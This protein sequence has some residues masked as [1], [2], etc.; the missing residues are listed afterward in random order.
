MILSLIWKAVILVNRIDELI[1]EKCPDGVEYKKLGTLCEKIKN[2]VWDEETKYYIDLSAVSIELHTILEN[3]VVQITKDSAPS[4]AKQVVKG[5]DILFGG[6]RPMQGR[7]CVVP[8]RYEGYIASTGFNIVRIKDKSVLNRY[9][10]HCMNSRNFY[11][12]VETVQHGASYPA[13][14]DSEMK[15]YEIPIP[16]IEIQQEIV[17]ILDKFTELEAGLQ[18]ELDARKK[19]YEYYRNRLFNFNSEIERKSVKIVCDY[20]SNFAAAGSFADVSKNVPYLSEPNYAQLIRTVDIKCNYT[21]KSP[22][23][24]SEHSFNYLWRVNLNEPS[25]VL[26]SVGNCGEV[27]Y[28]EPSDLPYERNVLAKNALLVRS[29]IVNMKFLK[30]YFETV[31][32]QKQLKKITSLLGQTKFNK[33]DF[34]KL[35]IPVPTKNEQERIVQI[36]ESFDKICNDAIQGLPAEIEARH[37]QYEYYRDK[38]LTFKRKEV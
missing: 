25:I 35:T 24:I 4:R 28:I 23:Y 36:M 17:R 3:E 32:F 8:D 22:I 1:K 6:T 21:S 11:D 5:S 20:I 9:I 18:D 19:Q 2:V 37:K 16:Q 29:S 38:L 10:Y 33:S 12:F 27:Y 30:L 34:E 31:E 26:P 15:E 14:N 7:I 13:I